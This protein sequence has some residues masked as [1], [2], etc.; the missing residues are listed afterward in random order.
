MD[1]AFFS[2]RRRN[3]FNARLGLSLLPAMGSFMSHLWLVLG[4]GTHLLLVLSF[5]RYFRG[6]GSENSQHL[7]CQFFFHGL[8]SG[9]HELYGCILHFV[10]E[11][12]SVCLCRSSGLPV[13]CKPLTLFLMGWAVLILFGG[14]GTWPVYEI[15]TLLF[16]SILFGDS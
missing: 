12:L 2:L 4:P 10:Q 6:Y 7:R 8:G 11:L 9:L 15:W 5:G 3:F 13:G 16:L 1:S 14:L